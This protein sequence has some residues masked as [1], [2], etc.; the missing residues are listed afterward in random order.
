MMSSFK[1]SRQRFETWDALARVLGSSMK[2]S[3]WVHKRKKY[4]RMTDESQTEA[5]RDHRVRGIAYPQ[6]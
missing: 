5:G 3:T 1:R 2:E 4:V 6:T